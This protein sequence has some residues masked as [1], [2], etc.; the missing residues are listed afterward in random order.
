MLSSSLIRCILRGLR[1]KEVR[2]PI[3]KPEQ[4]PLT[5]KKTNICDLKKKK[6]KKGIRNM[7]QELAVSTHIH[8]AEKLWVH[9]AK[10]EKKKALVVFC[11]MEGSPGN[12]LF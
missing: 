3:R 10:D 8:Y 4:M 1:A 5:D 7:T 12:I 2:H 6:H 9:V 11:C